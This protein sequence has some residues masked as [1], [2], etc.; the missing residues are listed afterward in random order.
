MMH[1][2]KNLPAIT[3]LLSLALSSSAAAQTKP[4]AV[5]VVDADTGRGVPLVELKTVNHVQFYTDSAG[6]V[7]FNEPGLM[8]R[9]VYFHIFSHGYDIPADGFGNRGKALKTV[10]GGSATIKIKRKNIA[11]RLY[12]VTG[13]GIYRDTVLLGRTAPIEQPLLNGRVLGQDSILTTIYQGKLYWFW[14]DT[15]RESYPLGQFHMSGATSLLPKDGGLSPSVGVNLNYFVDKDGFS[16]GMAPMKEPGP[17]WLDGIMTV[18]DEAGSER[19]VARYSRMKSLDVRLEQGF[20]VYND[21]TQTFEKTTA[22][23]NDL[24][25]VPQGQPFLAEVDG[26]P[27]FHFT[28]PYPHLR[29][30]ADF[31]SVQDLSQYEVF[32]C[33]KANS[34]YDAT[35]PPLDRDANGKLIWAWKRGSEFID[36]K[37]QKELIDRKHITAAEAWIDLRDIDSKKRITAHGGT[38]HWNDHRKKYIAIWLELFGT[39]PLG[40][41]W[42]TESTKPEGPYRFARKIVTHEKY[43]FYN[44]RH[45]PM[46]DEQAGRIIY[47]EGT[48]ADLISGAKQLT[49]RYDYNQIMYRLDLADERLKLE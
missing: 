5:E 16:R 46:F 24:I 43:S 6:L 27:H 10:P 4:F 9:D 20:M 22:I 45:H 29:V 49:P 12:R 44:P 19:M 17:V 33:L 34:K 26:V 35:N 31:K 32:T 42:F 48:Y 21:T 3:V 28:M 37:R 40:E 38:V 13:E 23:A 15:N 39:S 18:K 30:K 14:G 36:E 1:R 41:V 47:F 7:A 25:T 8:N 11:E 2:V